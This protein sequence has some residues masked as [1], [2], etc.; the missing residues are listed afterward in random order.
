MKRIKQGIINRFNEI[1]N[2]S[3]KKFWDK[4]NSRK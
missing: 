2:K 3:D 1:K 4:T